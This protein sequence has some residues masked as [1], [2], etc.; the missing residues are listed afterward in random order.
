MPG[1]SAFA[2]GCSTSTT[3]NTNGSSTAAFNTNTATNLSPCPVLESQLGGALDTAPGTPNPAAALPVQGVSGGVAIPVSSST[4]ATSALQTTGNTALTAINT[5]LGSPFQAGG[6]LGAGSA[7]IGKIDIL[8]NAGAIMD[9]AGQNASSP[10]N[11][12]LSG[13]QFNTTPTTITSG[14]ASPCQTDNAGNRLVNLKTAIPAGTNTIGK[15]NILGNAGG[16]LDTAAGT[17]ASTALGIQGIASGVAV[18]ISAASLPLPS[19]AATA[20]N[21]TGVQGTVAAGTAPTDMV[22]QGGVYNSTLPTLTTGQSAAVQLDSS[23]RPIISPSSLTIAQGST[24]SGQTGSLVFGAVTTAAPSYT[25]ALSNPLSLGTDGGLRTELATPA[26]S[27]VG[28][29]G[30]AAP[31]DA[32][33]A[34]VASSGNMVGLIQADNSAAIS[35]STATTTQLVAL[36][37]GKKIYVTSYDVVAGG[38]GNI[39]FEYGTGSSCGTGT[40][41]LTGAYNLVANSGISKGGGLGPVL[42][43]P[44]SN[45]LCVLTSAAVQ[46]SGSAAYTQF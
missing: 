33:Q 35:V 36:S 31:A 21:Q 12:L 18:G 11:Y 46:M 4:L 28:A 5:T 15:I 6:A 13:C 38:T 10:A 20:A 26:N 40:T 23:G 37:A 1:M 22:V 2:A 42:V 9:A 27:G 34:G 8:G 16:T 17:S 30:S 29:T 39:T 24:T 44:A 14:N 41:A 45:A 3:F 19:G 32:V 7:T 43:I 25:T